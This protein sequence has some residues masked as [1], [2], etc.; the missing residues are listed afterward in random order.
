MLGAVAFVLLIVCA[1]LAGLLLAR[2]AARRKEIAIRLALGATRGQIVRHLL[3]ESVLLAC[4]GG[5]LGLLVALWTVDLAVASIATQ[6]PF[7]IKFG[8]DAPALGF[9]AAISIVTGLLFGI[10]PALRASRPDVHTT[11]KDASSGIVGNADR[12]H[13]RALLVVG[14][15][16][17]AIVLLA[18]AG[19][20]FKN[21]LRY[22]RA[23]TRLRPHQPAHVES[24]IPRR[25]ISRAGAA[26]RRV[27]SAHRAREPGSRSRRAPAL[28]RTEFVAGFGGSDRADSRRRAVRRA[29]GA[30]PRFYHAVTPDYR[31][32]MRLP[33]VAGRDLNAQDRRAQRPSRSSIAGWASCC[34]PGASPIGHRIKLGS[35]DSL[36]WVTIVGVGRRHQFNRRGLRAQLRVCANGAG[37]GPRVTLYVRA[38]RDPA[39]ASR[40]ACAA[41]CAPWIP[42][43]PVLNL[44]T[45][46]Q[47]QHAQTWPYEMYALFLGGFAG[48]AILLAVIGLYGVIAYNAAQRTREIG[49]SHRLAREP[50]CRRSDRRTGWPVG[51]AG[52]GLGDSRILCPAA[53]H[54]FFAHWGEPD[55]SARLRRGLTTPCLGGA[56]RDLS[57]RTSRGRGWTRSLP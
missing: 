20:Q 25:T 36:P 51:G 50:A 11:L 26:E 48:L 55:R 10:L 49:Y 56:R 13:L 27:R 29:A 54:E 31:R 19:V 42:D 53:R 2:G 14:E 35:A 32:T 52:R 40:Q 5:V 37:A 17:M 39:G 47:E 18:G 15:L 24:G 16:A 21:F 12:S 38:P 9:C 33:L 34:G 45:L 43:L 30:S 4:A 6:V 44:R 1:N 22:Q 57:A 23:G 7:W 46:E 8:I 28:D 41:R 3:V